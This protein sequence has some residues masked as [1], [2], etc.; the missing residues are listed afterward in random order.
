MALVVNW[1]VGLNPC[2]FD[3]WLASYLLASG[4][5]KDL[6]WQ[7]VICCFYGIEGREFLLLMFSFALIRVCLCTEICRVSSGRERFP[8]SVNSGMFWVYL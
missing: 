3:F 8:D 4:F 2:V 5:G 1:F 6:G 7:R